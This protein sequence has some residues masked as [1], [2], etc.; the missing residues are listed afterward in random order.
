[1]LSKP[2]TI[3]SEYYQVEHK[4][5]YPIND[6]EI[7]FKTETYDDDGKLIETRWTLESFHHGAE[8]IIWTYKYDEKGRLIHIKSNMEDEFIEWHNYDTDEEGNDV[9]IESS[10]ICD[11]EAPYTIQHTFSRISLEGNLLERWQL[12]E[13]DYCGE[14]NYFINNHEA[15][16]LDENGNLSEVVFYEDHKLDP[17]GN[18]LEA[19]ETGRL[20]V[21]IKL[22]E[23]RKIIARKD[24]EGKIVC[25]EEWR[26]CHDEKGKE[27]IKE[28]I[29]EEDD[30]CCSHLE[31]EYLDNTFTHYVIYGSNDF[32]YGHTRTEVWE[33]Y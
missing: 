5:G 14:N 33:E 3:K 2:K 15:Y 16:I 7:S 11:P 10:I 8:D 28:Y 18:I 30:V 12:L 4:N 9:E 31:Y 24:S 17:D 1:M 13:N 25:S 27:Y 20:Q 23:N 32:E 19:K 6:E 21:D 26:Y 29:R 22:T